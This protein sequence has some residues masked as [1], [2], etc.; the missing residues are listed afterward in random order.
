[1]A[2]FCKVV[3]STEFA[4]NSGYREYQAQD[5]VNRRA[6]KTLQSML[7][8]ELNLSLLWFQKEICSSAHSLDNVICSAKVHIPYQAECFLAL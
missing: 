3:C 5:F 7:C 8:H 4:A 1:M 2:S 6:G